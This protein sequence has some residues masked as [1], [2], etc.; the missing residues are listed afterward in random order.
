MQNKPGADS[1]RLILILGFIFFFIHIVFALLY[2]KERMLQEDA[3][4]YIMKMVQQGVLVCEHNRFSVFLFQWM[5]LL[6]L[7]SGASLQLVTAIY[8]VSIDIF[9]LLVFLFSVYALKNTSGALLIILFLC[10]ALGRDFFVPITEY[11]LAIIS[12]LPLFG[13]SFDGSIKNEKKKLILASF[14]IIV[15]I[16]F[17]PVSCIAIGFIILYELLASQKPTRKH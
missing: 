5:P 1:R 13:L 4:F 14:L 10:L 17:H 7:K 15:A 12:A 2:F 3:P 11:S 8:S 16:N 9:L 6:A